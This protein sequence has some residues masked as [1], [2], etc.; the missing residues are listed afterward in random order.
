MRKTVLIFILFYS[1]LLAP[2]SSQEVFA[3]F[4]SNLQAS[5]R[6]NKITLTWKPSPSELSRYIIYSS[7]TPFSADTFTQARMIGSVG[8][9]ANSF[10]YPPA[11]TSSYYYAVIGSTD[12]GTIFPLFIPYRNIL[13]QP[14]SVDTTLTPEQISTEITNLE[15]AAGE[16]SIKLSFLSSRPNRQVIIYRSTNPMNDTNDLLS[17]TA[18]TTLASQQN[19][20]TDFPLPGVP[21]YY[22]VFDAPSSKSGKYS[23]IS[24]ENVLSAPVE[25]PLSST[26][27]LLSRSDVSRRITPLPFLI[28]NSGVLS[29]TRITGDFNRSIPVKV[30][31]PETENIWNS[32]SRLINVNG[33]MKSLL[34]PQ[35]LGEEK[36]ESPA[37]AS[38]QLAMIVQ[39]V[40]T[41]GSVGKVNW[42][43]VEKQLAA[44]M[45]VR[46]SEA[47]QDR[48]HFYLGQTYYYQ[49]KYS[50]AFFEFLMARDSYFSETRPWIDALF[51]L[52]FSLS[53]YPRNM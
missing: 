50:E 9:D 14:V 10:T 39:P 2:L 35:L 22:A 25:I 48:G 45:S 12:D 28:L 16:N 44:F 46:H 32:I 3:P 20:Y 33:Q 7:R 47:V 8:S 11:D 5:A 49:G 24:D 4:V 31:D 36:S 6:N 37:G 43:L 18:V 29:G 40:F 42:S 27:K 51:D 26:P 30:L 1:F 23:F 21:Y 15:A 13:M 19:S 34:Q 53:S 52:T 38:Y 41:A 17:A